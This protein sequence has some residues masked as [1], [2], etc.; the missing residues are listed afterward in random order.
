MNILHGR[1]MWPDAICQKAVEKAV[2]LSYI[3]M[4]LS[5][6]DQALKKKKLKK[7]RPDCRALGSFIFFFFWRGGW[8]WWWW[9]RN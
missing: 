7:E 1:I 6:Y 4:A 3:K 9:R 2:E 5:L 8:W